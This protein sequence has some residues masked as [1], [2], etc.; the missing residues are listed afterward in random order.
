MRKSDAAVA[1]PGSGSR[2][3]WLAAL[4]L[5]GALA[6]PV[7]APV[8]AQDA[9]ALKARHAALREVLARNAFGR[10]LHLESSQTAEALRGDI[11]ALVEQ[12]YA[13]VGPALRGIERWCDIL[14]LHQNVKSCRA[15]PA[16]AADRLSLNVG[17]R[18]DQPLDETHRLDFVYRLLADQPGYLQMQLMAGQGPLGTHNYRILLEV[19]ALDAGSSFLH[20]SYSY[21]FGLRARLAMQGYLATAGRS[22]AGF[23]VV[24]RDSRGRPLHIGGTRGVVERNTMRYYLAIESTLGALALPQAAR[25]EQRLSAWYAAVERYPLQLH[26]LERD[27]YLQMKRKEIRRMHTAGAA[28]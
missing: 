8:Q 2:Q 12:P 9:A 21:G 1:A 22:K 3:P 26:E 11:Y 4:I 20:L 16:T 10:P 19:V 27:E 14:I 15:P 17:R 7:L 28:R 5:C 23:S 13:V 18:F 6:V 24:G 25:L